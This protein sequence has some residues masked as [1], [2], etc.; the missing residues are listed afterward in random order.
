VT[1]LGVVIAVVEIAPAR[2]IVPAADKSR[3]AIAVPA[4]AVAPSRHGQLIA[5]APPEA[6]GAAG[7]TTRWATSHRAAQQI[8]SPRAVEP[9]LQ[10]PVVEAGVELS[11]QAAEAASVVA[12]EVAVVV[13]AEVAAEVA[14][15][16]E[17]AAA[18]GPIFG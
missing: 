16:V 9:A 10:A 1:V 7:A 17:A 3:V 14:V 2:A 5:R 11:P 15:A 13:S 12:V 6:P 4:R 18:G 8:C